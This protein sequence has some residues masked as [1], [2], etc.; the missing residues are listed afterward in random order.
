MPLFMMAVTYMTYIMK[1]ILAVVQL[2]FAG[3]V[4]SVRSLLPDL[5][6]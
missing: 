2:A 6:I 4:K 1:N 3:R 5:I